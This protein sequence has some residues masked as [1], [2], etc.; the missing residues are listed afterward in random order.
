MEARLLKIN[1]E[2]VYFFP[3][4]EDSVLID[5]IFDS[6]FLFGSVFVLLEEFVLL[7]ELEN[8]GIEFL[9]IHLYPFELEDL[10][11]EGIDEDIL[12]VTFYLS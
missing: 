2:E 6:L 5:V 12:L 9:V 3:E 10:V 11:F 7:S 8:E 1:F 4:V